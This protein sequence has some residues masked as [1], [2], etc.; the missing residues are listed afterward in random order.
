[1][2]IYR[3][4]NTTGADDLASRL[5][6]ELA[7]QVSRVAEHLHQRFPPRLA[8]RG[9]NNNHPDADDD[10]ATDEEDSTELENDDDEDTS[11]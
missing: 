11:T 2:Q 5:S 7:V 10:L 6:P 4:V 8:N 1:M 9:G 3:I